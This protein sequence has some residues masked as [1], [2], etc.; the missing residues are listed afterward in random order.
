M[1][2]SRITDQ[3]KVVG[4]SVENFLNE[5]IIAIVAVIVVVMLLLPMRRCV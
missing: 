4:D 2:I 5:L 1:T 3:S